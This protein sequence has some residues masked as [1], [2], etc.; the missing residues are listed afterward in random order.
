MTR[1]LDSILRHSL[2]YDKMTFGSQEELILTVHLSLKEKFIQTFSKECIEASFIDSIGI[3]SFLKKYSKRWGIVLGFIFLFVCVNLSSKFLW[4][5]N[6]DGNYSISDDEIMNIL[7][8]S[9]LYEGVYVPHLDYDKIHNQ[10]LLKT[11]KISWISINIDGNVANVK[12]K[13]R[14]SEEIKS[15]ATYANVVAKQD[16]QISM[17]TVYDGIKTVNIYDVVKKGDMLISGVMNSSSQGVRYVHADGIV[18]AY[19]TKNITIRIPMRQQ[20][21]V[22]TGNIHTELDLKV[23]IKNINIFK[24]YRNSYT[25]CDKIETSERISLFGVCPLPISIN[26]T[27]YLEYNFENVTYTQREAKDLALKEL[28]I[29]MDSQLKDAELI[30][31]SINHYCDFEYYYIECELYC[32]ENIAEIVEFEVTKE[33]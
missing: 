30:S 31:K 19:V 33:K 6:I 32:I 9:G 24:K 13:E 15:S 25:L 21:K 4:R 2:S 18:N 26:K 20:I 27:K 23:F 16:G 12:V 29:E 8:E 3:V 14:M 5:I 1:A 10:F 7:Y 17:V 11:D 28:K 22:Y